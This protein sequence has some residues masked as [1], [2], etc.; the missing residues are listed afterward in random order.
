MF[1]NNYQ[2]I[3]W[4][5]QKQTNEQSKSI[6]FSNV[7][8]NWFLVYI[9]SHGHGHGNG[10]SHGNRDSYGNGNGNGH[11]HGNGNGHGIG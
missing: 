9:N 5:S 11:G 7:F 10:K 2:N 1:E 8:L 6:K 4:V 3:N